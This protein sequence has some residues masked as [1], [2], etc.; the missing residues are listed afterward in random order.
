M[1]IVNKGDED[2]VYSLQYV[3]KV[4]KHLHSYHGLKVPIMSK[5]NKL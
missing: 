3:P 1:V 5:S 2:L 4:A